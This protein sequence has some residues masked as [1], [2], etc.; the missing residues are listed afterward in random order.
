M[1]KFGFIFHPLDIGLFADGFN[2]PDIKKK[3]PAL[4]EQVMTWFPP[5][6]RST[7]MGVKSFA[8]GEEI[9]GEMVLVTLLPEQMLILDNN[10]VA[11][12]IIEAGKLAERLNC[13]IVGLGAYASQ[14]G[15]KGMLVA[16]NLKIPVTTGSTYTIAV[17]IEAMLKAAEMI[18]L[19]LQEA[20]ISIIGATGAIGNV[21]S[22]IMASYNPAKLNLVARHKERLNTL[23]KEILE[24]QDAR[25]NVEVN[26][27]EAIKNADIII[28]A[29]STPLALIDVRILK[30]GTLICDISRPRN[31]SEG[32]AH[33]RSDILVI[34]GGIVKPPGNVDF[35]FSFG[36]PP[37]LAFA[38]MAETMILAFEEKY[39]SYSIGGNI[40]LEKV[41]EIT[42]LGKKHGFTLSE[43]RSFDKDVTSAQIENVRL[44]RKYSKKQMPL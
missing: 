1:K 5:F 7:V 38:C 43:F 32:A 39:E 42:K 28:T 14:V 10:F 11:K 26:I 35:H 29:T 19:K 33:L 9:E 15:K 44:S 13:K 21:F 24:S 36:L 27:Y 40:S 6:R 22:K 16:R 17:A 20:E 41:N 30:P 12:R 2:E 3:R 34:E 25:V 18:D 4:V 8:T 37:G 23:A 31:V